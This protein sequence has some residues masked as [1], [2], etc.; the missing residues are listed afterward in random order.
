MEP[1]GRNQWQI[2]GKWERSGNG[3]I[4]P[5]RLPLVATNCQS[6]RM[7]RNVMKKGLPG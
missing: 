6:E 4:R 1:S 3:E 2:G 5:E 7:V